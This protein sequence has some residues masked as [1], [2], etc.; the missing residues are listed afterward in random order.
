MYSLNSVPWDSF[1][2]PM[3]SYLCIGFIISISLHLLIAIIIYLL[4]SNTQQQRLKDQLTIRISLQPQIA[5]QENTPAAVEPDK[6]INKQPTA[7]ISEQPTTP[8]DKRSNSQSKE[9]SNTIKDSG[10]KKNT[11]AV[12]TP[13][14]KKPLTDIIKAFNDEQNT[15]TLDSNTYCTPQQRKSTVRNCSEQAP[16]SRQLHT[17]RFEGPLDNIFHTPSKRAQ[18]RR[19][20]ARINHLIMLQQHMDEMAKSA[21]DDNTFIAE[22]QLLVAREID[23]TLEKYNAVN[24]LEVIGA[25]FSAVKKH[26]SE[27]RSK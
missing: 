12:Q 15:K 26:L 19:D 2:P 27:Q 22:E 10:S 9:H 4:D 1:T 24:L 8:P 20:M 17:S 18:F 3:R 25:G 13:R 7:D 16:N 5:E 23:E 11:I 6:T 21:S 14:L